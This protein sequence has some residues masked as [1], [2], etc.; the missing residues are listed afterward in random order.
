M[1]I[2]GF[3]FCG[4]ESSILGFRVKGFETPISDFGIGFSEPDFS[5]S[6]FFEFRIFEW[7]KIKILVQKSKFCSLRSQNFD[8][9][10]KISIFLLPKF[11]N[12]VWG[13]VL[14]FLLLECHAHGV[15]LEYL[16]RWLVPDFLRRCWVEEKF[17]NN[18]I[19]LIFRVV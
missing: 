18:L 5:F 19:K 2:L 16:G 9:L 6:Q 13:F 15:R 10:I 12:F 8:F 3:R 14:E 7:R 4:F 11:K 17:H 1:P